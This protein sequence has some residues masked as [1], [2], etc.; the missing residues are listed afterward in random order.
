M[1]EPHEM[2]SLKKM[3]QGEFRIWMAGRF[4]SIEARLLR[5]EKG[6]WPW[7]LAGGGITGLGSGAVVALR[8]LSII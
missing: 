3:T 8:M 5:V 6:R 2:E 1:M 7:V 4:A